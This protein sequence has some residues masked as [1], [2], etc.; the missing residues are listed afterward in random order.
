[1]AFVMH[2]HRHLI[3]YI[4]TK[5]PAVVSYMQAYL[6]AIYNHA[7]AQNSALRQWRKPSLDY[8]LLRLSPWSFDASLIRIAEHF[9]AVFCYFREEGE[10]GAY[11]KLFREPE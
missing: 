2:Q 5:G 6:L 9:P 4:Y 10:L 8:G 7:C 11:Q 3:F 1:M